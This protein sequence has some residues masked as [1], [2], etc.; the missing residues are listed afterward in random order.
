[1]IAQFRQCV[2]AEMQK[3]EQLRIQSS[4]IPVCHICFEIQRALVSGMG[5][6]FHQIFQLL[7]QVFDHIRMLA[8]DILSFA[9]IVF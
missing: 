4:D 8:G 6:L 9:R 5:G 7:R 1:M 3:G 2:L